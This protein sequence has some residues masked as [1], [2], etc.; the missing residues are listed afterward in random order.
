MPRTDP[1]PKFPEFARTTFRV[2][3]AHRCIDIRVDR[4]AGDEGAGPLDSLLKAHGVDEYAFITAYN[5]DGMLQ[6]DATNRRAQERLRAH[7]DAIGYQY[8]PGVGEPDPA[9]DGSAPWPPE[10]SFLVLGM[11]RDA[12]KR[13][14]R[15]FGQAAVVC[16]RIGARAQ[17]V[18][19][20]QG[21][22][23]PHREE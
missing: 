1:H 14:G 13:L 3:T 17:L 21:D 6:D 5:P 16:G 2:R 20:N 15:E 22:I 11:S 23:R 4:P 12:A 10:P 19:S 9:P 18:S 8:L 7:L